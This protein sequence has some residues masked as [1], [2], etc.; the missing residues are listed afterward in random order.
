MRLLLEWERWLRGRF[1]E[2]LFFHSNPCKL[3]SLFTY[4][5]FDYNKKII[6]NKIIWI[7]KSVITG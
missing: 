6:G 7:N 1:K 3:N 4:T 2:A 5:T